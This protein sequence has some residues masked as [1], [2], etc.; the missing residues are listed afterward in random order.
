MSSKILLFLSCFS[1]LYSDFIRDNTLEI[2]LDTSTNLIWQD[3][4]MVTINYAT[5]KKNY[6]EESIVDCENLTIAGFNDWRMPNINELKT[7]IVFKLSKPS[8]SESFEYYGN[9]KAGTIIYWS[10]TTY[11]NVQGSYTPKDIIY[12]DF[13]YA[14]ISVGGKT[15]GLPTTYNRCVRTR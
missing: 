15:N 9:Q 6:W 4:K 13:N 3:D 1:L 7:L 5:H 12:V 11:N 10:S 8:L 14:M 2:V